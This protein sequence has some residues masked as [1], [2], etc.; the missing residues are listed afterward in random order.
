[1]T[2]H[3]P[4]LNH[5]VDAYDKN[6]SLLVFEIPVPDGKI[7]QLR[8]IMKWTVPEDEIYG[9]DLDPKQITQLEVLIG[10]P[11]YDPEYDFQLSCYGSE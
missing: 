3:Y 8:A 4:K 11:F 9:Y 2:C 1:M 5:T 10:R 7:D 6:T